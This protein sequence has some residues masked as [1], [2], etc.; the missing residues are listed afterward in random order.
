MVGRSLWLA[1]TSCAQQAAAG[2]DQART[3]FE[4]LA[5]IERARVVAALLAV[6]L[7]GIAIVATVL[8]WGRRLR[9]IARSR[10]RL[11]RPNDDQWYR[12]PLVPPDSS[13][14]PPPPGSSSP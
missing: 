13:Q 12:K 1:A 8:I 7:L 14:S 5:P 3:L 11:A 10:P 4:R 6:V 9:R 2:G